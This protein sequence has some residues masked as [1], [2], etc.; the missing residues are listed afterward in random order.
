MQ[1]I[2][3]SIDIGVPAHV[4]Y[5]QLSRFE[6]YPRFMQDVE[7]VQQLDDIHL[8]WTTKIADRNVE[9]DATIVE[10]IPD[11]CIAWHNTSGPTNSGRVEVQEVSAKSSRVTMALESGTEQ[12]PGLP[13]GGSE[14]DMSIRLRQD[15]A[16]LKQMIE[17][18]SATIDGTAPEDVSLENVANRTT[19]SDYSLSQ[20][21]DDAEAQQAFTVAEEVNF[22]EQSEAARHVGRMPDKIDVAGPAAQDPA[23][24]VA[25]SMKR[26]E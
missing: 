22:D 6:N 25:E 18:R 7:A 4:V 24:A 1:R 26:R 10:Q 2:T 19:Q 12:P 14:A 3:Q 20:G 23:E 17:A 5:Q 11:R 8:H 16:R 9:W 15:L 13:A 21:A